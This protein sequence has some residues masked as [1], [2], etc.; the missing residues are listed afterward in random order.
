MA[1]DNDSARFTVPHQDWTSTAS[2]ATETA[3]ELRIELDAAEK[4]GRRFSTSLFSKDLRLG[5]RASAM[6]SGHWQ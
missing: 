1:D 5:A 2:R 6:S 3:R 4:A